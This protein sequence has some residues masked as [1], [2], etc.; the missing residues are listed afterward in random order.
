MCVFSDRPGLTDPRKVESLTNKVINS[1]KEHTT[2][3]PQAKNKQNYFARI[4]E[5][6]QTVQ[7]LRQEG[8]QKLFYLIL[9]LRNMGGHHSVHIPPIVEE[10]ASQVH[11]EIIHNF[12]V[13]LP[14]TPQRA[15]VVKF[16]IY[17]NFHTL[18]PFFFKNTKLGLS[19]FPL[20]KD[21]GKS[22]IHTVWK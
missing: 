11:W 1:L 22:F 10:I 19:I 8:R 2:Y 21:D 20:K 12:F 15:S 17:L 4:V 9:E 5:K 6:L 7:V 13:V 14:N 18:F 16:L 3:H